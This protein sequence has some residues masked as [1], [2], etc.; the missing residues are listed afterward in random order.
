MV[1]MCAKRWL[2]TLNPNSMTGP[3]PE[4]IAEF[5][6]MLASRPP[7]VQLASNFLIETDFERLQCKP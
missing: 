1:E 5:T 2:A 3:S 4:I 6:L 7:F